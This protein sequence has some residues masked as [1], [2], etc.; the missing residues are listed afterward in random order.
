MRH[1]EGTERYANELIAY[2]ATSVGDD[3]GEGFRDCSLDYLADFWLDES[4]Q[5]W[6][7]SALKRLH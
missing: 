7:N 6:Q 3:I 5:W 2:Y 1:F 4:S